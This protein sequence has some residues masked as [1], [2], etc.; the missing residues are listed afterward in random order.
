MVLGDLSQRMQ[1]PHLLA[2][3]HSSANGLS[4]LARC[5]TLGPASGSVS[6]TEICKRVYGQGTAAS[7]GPMRVTYNA[8]RTGPSSAP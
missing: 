4:A 5:T 7:N 3:M 6:S 1:S 8:A 2:P